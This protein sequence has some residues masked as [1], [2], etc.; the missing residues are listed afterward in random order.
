MDGRHRVAVHARIFR[1]RARSPAPGG[2]LCQWAH[3]YDI[4]SDDLQSI[5]ATF[6]SVFPE[7]TLWLVG[8]ADVLLLG[9]TEPLDARIGGI[10]EAMKRPGVAADLA[11]VGVSGAVSLDLVVR[12]A[13]RRAEGVG[14]QRAAADR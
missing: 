3:T 5:V 13:G 11:T 1:R 9:S 6:L 4:S 14:R 12:R 7:R 2:V 10:A 8:D